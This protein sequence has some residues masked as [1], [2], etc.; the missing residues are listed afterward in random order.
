MNP[1]V[2]HAGLSVFTRLCFMNRNMNRFFA[3]VLSLMAVAN[4]ALAQGVV[5]EIVWVVGDEAILLS[6]VEE[7]RIRAQY[8]GSD[9][10]GDPY[11]YIPEQLALQKL[12]L[13][14]A[15]LDSIKIDDKQVEQQVDQRVSYL[16]SQFG[17]IDRME[18]YFDKKV[19]KIRDELSEMVRNQMTI[20]QVQKK[21]VG[22]IKPTPAEVRRFYNQ[23]PKDSL[24]EIPEQVEVQI[25]A[26]QPKV[27]Q[28]AIDAVKNRLH[29]FQDR[30]EKGESSF[31]TLAS[32]YSEDLAS[33]S[34]GGE[35]G[36]MGKGQ[37][38]PEYADVAFALKDPK[39]V[40]RIVK[41]D[42][43]Y[44]IIQLVDRKDD[45]VNTRHILLKPVLTLA[46]RD[47]A[48]QAADSIADAVR[49]DKL[50]FEQAVNLYS[51]DKSTNKCQ[52][53]LTNPRSGD[54]RFQLKE[55]A[56]EIANIIASMNIGEISRTFAMKNNNGDEAY[57]IVKLRNRIPTHK[58]N[59]TEDFQLLKQMYTA[60]VSEDKLKNWIVEKQ[61]SVYVK[62]GEKWQNCNFQYPG[63]IKDNTTTQK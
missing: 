28:E 61:K 62:I 2:F 56:P 49:R 22:D 12:Y 60:K 48:K 51:T 8:D 19:D 43:G 20:Q 11:C 25:L 47:S 15:I 5:D 38:V 17:S 54:T 41:S 53:I 40:S 52:G 1:Y 14:Q 29:E 35:L 27:R 50:T 57:T 59:M 10:I 46:D 30:V 23:L 31:S 63:W 37:L 18:N 42:F 16:E 6:D 32:L 21:I 39:R 4:G 3:A 9:P 33:A 26:V 55:V 7:Q 44:H 13:D 34:Q 45:K 24:P 58:A 36:Y